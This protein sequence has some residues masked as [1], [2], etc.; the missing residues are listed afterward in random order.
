MHR[1]T[2]GLYYIWFNIMLIIIMN[3]FL[4]LARTI[5]EE[6]TSDTI[7]HHKESYVNSSEDYDDIH[8]GDFHHRYYLIKY[9]YYNQDRGHSEQ[10][11][12]EYTY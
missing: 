10:T 9:K 7:Y 5:Y 11:R 2:N 8:E 1:F 12:F 6:Y 4:I 3:L